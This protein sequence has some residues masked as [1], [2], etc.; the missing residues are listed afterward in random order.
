MCLTMSVLTFDARL[1][2]QSQRDH[3]LRAGRSP[4]TLGQRLRVLSRARHSRWLGGI[5]GSGDGVA[6]D[7]G[8][9]L[10]ARMKRLTVRTAIAVP[11]EAADER[12]DSEHDE[13]RH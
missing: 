10:G 11:A 1:R 6:L 7:A 8:A 5:R 2:A 13:Y 4:V 9:V 3:G 12:D